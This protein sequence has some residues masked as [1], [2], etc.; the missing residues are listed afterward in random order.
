[1][2]IDQKAVAARLL[3]LREQLERTR[4]N[5]NAI[6]GAIQDCEFW[7]QFLAEA[8]QVS[9]GPEPGPPPPSDS[10]PAE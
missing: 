1:M 5:M 10:P 8:P 9:E 3:E 4:A 2:V 7:L 6:S